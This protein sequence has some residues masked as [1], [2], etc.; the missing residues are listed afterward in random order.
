MVF[1][2]WQVKPLQG[3]D[4]VGALN[5]LEDQGYC[6]L[7]CTSGRFDGEMQGLGPCPLPVPTAVCLPR[8]T[9]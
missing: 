8:V 7:V 5:P 2:C 6:W 9:Q 4:A 1:C 3:C